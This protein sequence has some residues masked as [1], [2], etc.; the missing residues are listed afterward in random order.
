MDT[1][2]ADNMQRVQLVGGDHLPS[3]SPTDR[4]ARSRPGFPLVTARSRVRRVRVIARSPDRDTVG[5]VRLAA[6][7]TR[8]ST[9]AETARVLDGRIISFSQRAYP[10]VAR[11]ALFVIFFWFGLVKVLGLS[12]AMPLA[13]ALTA[14]TVGIAH[15]PVLF[16]ALAV[17]ECFIGLLFL[18]PRA[19][20]F[21]IF[22]L[23][24]HL[25]VV[26]APL[27]LVP[28]LTWRTILV[29]TMDG[30]YIIKNVLILAAACGLVGH[31]TPLRPAQ[32]RRVQQRP[33]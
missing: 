29:P 11:I 14:K 3:H 32:S 4:S 15:F 16:N 30:Q 6:P 20:R 8:W 9:V 24:T 12:D 27:V 22:L 10:W 7:V 31:A 13:E 19:A 21:A 26:C 23:L 17:F 5:S 18:I 1:D 25:A 28:E 2:M 33:T